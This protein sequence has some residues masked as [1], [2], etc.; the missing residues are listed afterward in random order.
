MSDHLLSTAAEIRREIDALDA[1]RHRLRKLL[2]IAIE[3]ELA[4][5]TTAPSAPAPDPPPVPTGK[6][7]GAAQEA[8]WGQTVVDDARNAADPPAEDEARP[9]VGTGRKGAR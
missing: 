3:D 4:A 7:P 1:R 6:P 5:G 8:A 2:A 9:A